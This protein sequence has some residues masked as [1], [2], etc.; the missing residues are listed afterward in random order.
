[1]ILTE[2]NVSID[3]QV[4]GKPSVLCKFGH[5]RILKVA[6]QF[7]RVS[8][9]TD[10]ILLNFADTLGIILKDGM[11]IHVE[12]ELR[13][14]EDGRAVFISAREINILEEEPEKYDNTVEVKFAELVSVSP[15][16]PYQDSSASLIRCKFEFLRKHSRKATISA[17]VWDNDAVFMANTAVV[18]G[19]YHFKGRLQRHISSGGHGYTELS[20]WHIDPVGQ[21]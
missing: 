8:G 16:I 13:S 18:G 3:L 12:G 21:E 2:S 15:L 10:E 14:N 20:V 6:T 11:F 4:V 19:R 9:M 1:M 5:R 17:V 7:K